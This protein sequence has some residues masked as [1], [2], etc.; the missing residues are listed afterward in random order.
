MASSVALKQ[1]LED[2]TILR[3][4]WKISMLIYIV[5]IIVMIRGA[6]LNAAAFAGNNYLAKY[7]FRRRAGG[8]GWKSEAWQRSWSLSGGNGGTRVTEPSFLIESKTTRKSK[9]RR[10]KTSWRLFT[11]QNSI[12]WD[13]QT[14]N[15]PSLKSVNPLTFISP[16]AAKTRLVCWP[17]RASTRLCHF[18][19]AL[20]FG[21]CKIMET[22]LS[23]VCCSPLGYW[24]GLCGIKKLAET[25]KSS[26]EKARQWL[27]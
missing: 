15:L 25:A 5:S 26:E 23:Q 1:Y 22:K 7:F 11:R 2:Q 20:D 13:I 17:Q 3:T 14:S 21:S 10:S 24:K 19:F 6:I 16:W 18:S 8:V 27:I 4:N 12:T 9:N